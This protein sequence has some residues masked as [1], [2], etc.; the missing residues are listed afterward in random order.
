MIINIGDDNMFDIKGIWKT[1]RMIQEGEELLK[2][3]GIKVPKSNFSKNRKRKQGRIEE[4]L[5]PLRD[6]KAKGR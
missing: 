6:L 2:Q 5:E 1:D 3:L 4:A